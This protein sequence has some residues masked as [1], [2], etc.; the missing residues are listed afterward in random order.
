MAT[1]KKTASTRTEAPAEDVVEPEPE[2][3]SSPAKAEAPR[4]A[5]VFVPKVHT[6]GT[7]T[8]SGATFSLSPGVSVRL[9]RDD[10][11]DLVSQDLGAIQGD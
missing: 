5:V 1:R 6:T 7:H 4:K 3:A 2:E 9:S 8:L 10:A 11:D